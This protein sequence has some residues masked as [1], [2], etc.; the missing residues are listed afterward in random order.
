M[1]LT[2]FFK[3]RRE[4]SENLSENYEREAEEGGSSSE[5]PVK[6]PIDE[7]ALRKA[8]ELLQEYKNGKARLEKRLRDHEEYWKMHQ[9]QSGAGNAHLSGEDARYKVY[10]TP[11]LHTCLE[12]R[13]A[14][15]MD[16][17]P[18]CNFLPQ[19]KDDEEEAKRLS[20]IAP[21]I[22]NRCGYERTYRRSARYCLMH[23]A[24]LQGA[25]WDPAANNS[26]GAID[27][28][29]VDAMNLF[30]QP[31]IRNIQDSANVF[32]TTLI[33]NDSLKRIYP[34]AEGKLGK[35]NR[36]VGKYLYD[37]NIDTTDKSVVVDWYY[38]KNEGGKNV[39][40]YCKYVNEA[41]L[42]S[43]E[44]EGLT[45]G[46]YHHG[47][48]PFVMTPL[49]EVQGS[50]FGYGLIDVCESTQLQIDLLNK[51]ICDNAVEGSRPR[52]FV[53]GDNTI[54]EREFDDPTKRI[55]RVEGRVDEEHVA[56]IQTADLPGIYVTHHNNLIEQLKFCTANQDVN[57]GSA[58]SGVTSYSAL[59]ALQE[60]SGK[61][62]RDTNRAFYDSFKEIMYFVVELMRQ[63]YVTP[64]QFRIDGEKGERE[65]ITYTNEG[66]M[67]Q[68]QQIEGNPTAPRVPQFD[69]EVTVE[70][71][72]PYKK[73]E[74]NEFILQL[75]NLGAFN[76]SNADQALALVDHLDFEQKD[77]IVETIKRNKTM[78]DWLLQY[79]QV[80]LSLAQQVDPAMAEELAMTITQAD[81]SLAGSAPAL[82]DPA[83]LIVEK[84]HPYGK[85]SRSQARES[86]Q[87]N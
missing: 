47:K 50:P 33:D 27:I 6:K 86:T 23:G 5:V 46:Y 13:I 49:F 3:K 18:T 51:A 68:A 52:Y 36:F 55:V 22:L 71:A 66:L 69:V 4:D 15:A 21:V 37:E 81:Q 25:F 74:H 40:H 8:N 72:N 29:D 38:K 34:Q 82:I 2:D 87:V 60:T 65:Y 77:R 17:Y 31:G 57:N 56:K 61:K 62:P 39:L 84:E 20:K 32:Y 59:A 76:P 28:K 12:T 30:W 85:R 54:N 48:Y 79:Q 42:Y 44:N 75:Y 24:F 10:S 67:P 19:A 83:K 64:Q 9:W 16:A 73:M 7:K 11:W 45:D 70:K 63:F 58:P 1:S 43:S 80:A 14:D 53:S 35:S 26:L 78:A 41:V